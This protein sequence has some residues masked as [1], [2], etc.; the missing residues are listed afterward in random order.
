MQNAMGAIEPLHDAIVL[1]IGSTPALLLSVETLKKL[2]IAIAKLPISDNAHQLC[3]EYPSVLL[4]YEHEVAVTVVSTASR[5]QYQHYLLDLK[6]Y[7]QQA[8]D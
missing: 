4:R 1:S 5:I 6:R 8:V 3:L 7:Y 2:V